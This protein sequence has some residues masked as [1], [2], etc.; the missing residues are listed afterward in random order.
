[1]ANPKPRVVVDET[2]FRDLVDG[3]AVALTLSDGTKFDMILSDIGWARMLLTIDDARGLPRNI[4]SL[5]P[6]DD[7]D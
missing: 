4:V 6:E 2:A 1:M 3:R 7:D 5:D